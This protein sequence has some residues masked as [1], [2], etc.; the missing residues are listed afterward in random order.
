MEQLVRVASCSQTGLLFL[1]PDIDV[2]LS[3]TKVIIFTVKYAIGYDLPYK[4]HINLFF[5]KRY[6][7]L[8]MIYPSLQGPQT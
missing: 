7:N 8:C 6:Y 1:Q 2:V 3:I 4:C 5:T